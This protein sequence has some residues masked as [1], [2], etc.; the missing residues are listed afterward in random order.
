MAIFYHRN[1]Q[2]LALASLLAL[3]A[4]ISVKLWAKQCVI[5]IKETKTGLGLLDIQ[6]NI[7]YF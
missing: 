4:E 2:L 1:G 5:N 7:G 6:P 3:A